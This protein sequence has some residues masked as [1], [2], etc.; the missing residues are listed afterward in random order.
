MKYFMMAL[1]LLSFFISC[2]TVKI[3]VPPP[4]PSPVVDPEPITFP[5]TINATT[6][7]TLSINGVVAGGGYNTTTSSVP[8]QQLVLTDA[9]SGNEADRSCG[10]QWTQSQARSFAQIVPRSVPQGHIYGSGISVSTQARGG[11]WR[12][13]IGPFCKGS[14]DE[15]GNAFAQA[16]AFTNLNYT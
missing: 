1:A 5:T 15:C 11:F 2:K 9:R 7:G 13:K 3:E 10:T 6:T 16:T 14:N 8:D 4:P 12:G